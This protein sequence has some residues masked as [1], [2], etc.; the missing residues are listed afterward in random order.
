[1]INFAEITIYSETTFNFDP[2]LIPG[3]TVPIGTKYTWATPTFNPAGS[4]IGASEQTIPQDQVSQTLENTGNTPII[5]TYTITPTTATCVGDEFILE[6]TVNP[7]IKPNAIVTNI[8]CFEENNGS[9]STN[10]VGGLPFKTGN[11]YLT[12]WVGPNGFTS[13]SANI[14]SLEAGTYTLTIEDKDGLHLI[15]SYIITQPEVL[16]ITK[17]VEK[18]I[19]CFNENDGA[20]EVTISGGTLPYT[21][22]WTTVDGSGIIPN[23][24]KQN[25]LTAGNYTLEIIDKNNCTISTNVILTQPEGLKIEVLSKQDILCFGDASG[26][27]EINVTGG[28]EKEI[29]TGIFDYLYSWS[30]PNGFTSTSKNINDLIAGTY[31]LD[32]TDN[33]GCSTS[34]SILIQQSSE[35]KITYTKTDVTCYGENNGNISVSVTGGLAPYKISWSNLANGF[36]QSNLSADT[37]IATVTD[38]NNCVKDVSITIEQP[39]FYISPTVSPISC[40]DENDGSISLNVT[41]GISPI[42]VVWSDD[43]TAG[44]QRNNLAAGTYTVLITDI[45]T[46]PIE[47]TFIITNP[48]KINVTSSYVD[49]ID[50]NIANSGSINLDISGGTKPYSFLWN[51]GETTKDLNNIPPGDYSVEITDASGCSVNRQ[52]NIFRQEPINITLNETIETDCSIKKI[53]TI[54]EPKVT[55]GFLPYKYSWSAGTTSGPDNAIMTTSQNGAYT[56]T[57]T[58]NNGCTT[59]KS[60]IIDVP[61]I[62]IPDFKYNAFAIDKYD[63][64][65]IN[66]P[67]QFTNLSTGLYSEITWN[68]GDGTPIIKEENP[69]H[70]YDQVGE[71]KITLSIEYDAGCTETVERTVT[72]TKGYLLISPNAF[73]PNGDG[74]NETIRPS[75]RGLIEIEMTIFNTWGTSIYYEKGNNLIGWDGM[76]KGNP[77]EN[78]NYIMVVKGLTFYN[79]EI[80]KTSPLTLLK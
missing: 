51:T 75:H 70:T 71:F 6:V 23:A 60:L 41:G 46:C 2:K 17:D 5:V 49:A 21:Y 14:T 78:G 56:L 45:G 39:I 76:I 25:E 64:L 36:S 44:V 50:C 10:I 74:H 52:F 40:N 18:N 48:P 38:K 66:D 79:K 28:T 31:V 65:S 54:T 73:T 69:V 62:G 37:Y 26:T 8:S 19:S 7:N 55:G 58:D 59:T 57:V 24:E 35:I 15:P 77:A 27:I 1:M 34:T 4:I 9:I 61:T 11:Q 30:G 72:I 68:F 16:K 63:L 12:S 53:N 43:A 80:V 32:V 42:T 3:N 22:N 20:I 67:I 33:L 13:N 47:E 29:S